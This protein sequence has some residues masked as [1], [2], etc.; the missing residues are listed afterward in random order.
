[1]VSGDFISLDDLYVAYRKAKVDAFYERDHVTALDF[2]Y[3]ER[4][5]KHNLKLLLQ[6]LS[7]PFPEWFKDPDFVGLA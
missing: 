3:Y 6:R 5:L 1:M 4:Y 7:S 2:A